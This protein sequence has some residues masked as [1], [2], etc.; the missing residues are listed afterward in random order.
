MAGARGAMVPA[1]LAL[2]ALTSAPGVPAPGAAAE[3]P[4]ALARRLREQAREVSSGEACAEIEKGMDE[5]L[6]LMEK[7]EALRPDLPGGAGGGPTRERARAR[8]LFRDRL[9]RHSDLVTALF[10]ANRRESSRQ[11]GGFFAGEKDSAEVARAVR[12]RAFHRRAQTFGDAARVYLRAHETLGNGDGPPGGRRPLGLAVATALLVGAAAWGAR[13]RRPSGAPDAGSR[14]RL[15]A[16]IY[17]IERELGRGGMGVVLEALDVELQR[18]V[19][20]KRMRREL[21]S[22][23]RALDGFLNEARVVAALKHPYIVEIHT[24]VREGDELYLVF[25]YVAGRPLSAELA[26]GKRL[27][28]ERLRALFGQVAEA[29]DYAHS[30][31]VLHRDLKPAN[32]MVTPQDAIKVMDFGLA[33]RARNS[34]AQATRAG[35]AGTLD[36]MAPEAEQGI[37]SRESDLY[38]LG[39]CLYEAATG[40][41]PFADLAAKRAGGFPPP[42]AVSGVSPALD[43][44]LTRALH[45][46]PARRFHTGAE[47]L[48]SLG[49][50]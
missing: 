12:L 5:L 3:G 21:S 24:F 38:S 15:L 36:Y 43:P 17:R 8:A 25:E 14:E 30:Q 26:G 9:E 49:A 10:A 48:A 6:R 47:L 28:P 23:P 39:V 37:V 41:L 27:P 19:A 1:V 42:S 7:L 44:V 40:R 4:T 18:R 22:D 35:A 50:A 46:D 13:R 34:A 11:V 29:L 32:I 33:H 31:R 16:G 45:P 20:L 2:V